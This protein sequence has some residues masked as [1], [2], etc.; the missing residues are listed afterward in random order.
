MSNL[1]PDQKE[2]LTPDQM[3]AL[4]AEISE[5]TGWNS[6]PEG[7][8]SQLGRGYNASSVVSGMI[9]D[10]LKIGAKHD[11]DIVEA[12]F[13]AL[14]MHQ[15]YGRKQAAEAEAVAGALASQLKS[16][17]ARDHAITLQQLAARR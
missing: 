5:A 7:I 17:F 2:V 3:R 16:K 10:V 13:W 4:C 9:G 11:V 6:S 14:S 15:S 1:I 8:N 12:V